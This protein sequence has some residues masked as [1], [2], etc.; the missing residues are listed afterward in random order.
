[1][2][3]SSQSSD[4]VFLDT[5]WQTLLSDLG[6]EDAQLLTRFS[7]ASISLKVSTKEEIRCIFD[8]N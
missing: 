3:L 7:I 8:D 1:M 4:D 6:D 5:P 2:I